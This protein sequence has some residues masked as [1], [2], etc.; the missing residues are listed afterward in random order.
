[1]MCSAAWCRRCRLCST[2][3]LSGT[4]GRSRDLR[5]SRLCSTYWCRKGRSG[6]G[7]RS[8]D[9]RR[10]RL[11]GTCWRC[12]E[13]SGSG[14]SSRDLRRSGLWSTYW[15]GKGRSGTG[16]R[17]R[18]VRRCRLCS[19]YGCRTL[20]SCFCKSAVILPKLPPRVHL[21]VIGDASFKGLHCCCKCGSTQPN[22]QCKLESKRPRRR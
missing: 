2:C 11:C 1:M 10:C 20:P 7:D 8:R 14:G 21:P 22:K 12:T 3:E 16:S 13:Q 6:T 15:C 9:V 17:S 18:E 4:G 19:T 5:C